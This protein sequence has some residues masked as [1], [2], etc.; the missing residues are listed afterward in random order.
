MRN[1]ITLLLLF[2]ALH[3]S[4]QKLPKMEAEGRVILQDNDTSYQFYTTKPPSKFK[5]ELS[6]DYAWFQQDT[7]LSTQGGV[8][9]RL[10]HGSFKK[11][12]P[13]NNLLEEGYYYYGLKDGL[14]KQWYPNGKLKAH[15]WWIKGDKKGNFAEY[16][17]TGKV[18]RE[19][20]YRN[21]VVEGRLVEIDGNGNSKAI[22]YKD[23]RK[24][25]TQ[26]NNS[27][28]DTLQSANH[29]KKD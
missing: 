11:M 8:G 28:K 5:L 7:I 21:N 25:D 17:T 20:T 4:S 23:G 16:D 3:G 1:R 24:I 19:G 27:K 9:T 22:F 15:V 12:Y 26:T 29:P 6:K 2:G 14:W 10:L 18:I 13:S